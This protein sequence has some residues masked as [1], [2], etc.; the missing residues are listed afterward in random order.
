MNLLS[1]DFYCVSEF[2]DLDYYL[3]CDTELH[4]DVSGFEYKQAIIG[5]ETRDINEAKELYQKFRENLLPDDSWETAYVEYVSPDCRWAVVTDWGDIY[6]SDVARKQSL[7]YEKKKMQECVV[8]MLDA[9][10][11]SFVIVKNG[12]TYERL[13]EEYYEKYRE[14]N[15]K[16]F[17]EGFYGR[18]T[19][20]EEG[21]LAAGVKRYE[22][23]VIKRI[24]N[25]AILWSFSLDEVKNAVRKKWTVEQD[26]AGCF[27]DIIQ[28][29]GDEEEGSIILQ[30][31]DSSFFRIAYPSNEVT[32]LGE[33]MYPKIPFRLYT[34]LGYQP[35]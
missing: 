5:N 26:D 28:F 8:S 29:V 13:N 35:I 23:I 20:N 3:F 24:D 33:Y 27:A 12:D 11:N 25:G 30:R 21:N 16:S 19:L 34:C 18:F 4:K 6:R 15:S 9:E 22:E 17:S 10:Y 32:Y 14:L 2:T 7:F 1:K 31:G